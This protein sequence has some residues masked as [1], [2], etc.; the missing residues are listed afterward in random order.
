MVPRSKKGQ[1]TERCFGGAILRIRVPL[2]ECYI[3]QKR[4][5]HQFYWHQELLIFVLPWADLNLL[6]RTKKIVCVDCVGISAKFQNNVCWCV[7][8]KKIGCVDCVGNFE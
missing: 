3:V 4:L 5:T 8:Q 1:N 6:V 7:G 2:K